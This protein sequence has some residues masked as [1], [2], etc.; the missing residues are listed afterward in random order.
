MKY[1][2]NVMYILHNDEKM[3]RW[4]K[5]CKYYIN[6]LEYEFVLNQ[7]SREAYNNGQNQKHENKIFKKEFRSDRKMVIHLKM[8]NVKSQK[9]KKRKKREI[10]FI[11]ETRW[12]NFFIVKAVQYRKRNA[13]K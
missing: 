5:R 7:P 8:Q 2:L 1:K 9:M 3:S 13:E 12:R 4:I 10:Y 11:Y 6:E